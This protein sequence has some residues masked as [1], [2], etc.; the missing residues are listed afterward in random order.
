MI[1]WSFVWFL[2]KIR[3]YLTEISWPEMSKAARLESYE[4]EGIN[5]FE[6]L[7][8]FASLYSLL[9]GTALIVAL[10][11]AIL[12]SN[13]R[14]VNW[15]VINMSFDHVGLIH[16]I[17]GLHQSLDEESFQAVVD[18][19]PSIANIPL[20]LH[21]VKDL[22]LSQADADVLS[23]G[24]MIIGNLDDSVVYYRFI[25]SDQV[26]QF[27][28]VTTYGPLEN[29]TSIA[30]VAVVLFMT[31][32]VFIWVW[33][34]S[35]KLVLLDQ[36]ATRFGGGDF[37]S[38]V[39]ENA[40]F[41]VGGLN[42]S[43]NQMARRIQN[44]IKGNKNLTNAVAHELRTPVS[45]IRFQLDMM[46]DE[47]N[48]EKR[49][50]YMYGISDDIEELGDLVDELLTFA[51]FEREGRAQNFQE[52][53]LHE[54]LNNVV[55]ASNLA[56]AIEVMYDQDWLEGGSESERRMLPYEPKYLERAIG[57]LV[58]NAQK[59]AESQVRINVERSVNICTIL[60]DDDGPGIP[61]GDRE[62]IFEPF[63]RLDNSRTR[64]TGGYGLGL[65]IVKQIVEWHGGE[66]TISDSPIGGARFSLS[67]PINHK[68]ET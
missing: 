67:W 59:Y 31:L 28:P 37:H 7:R 50:Q 46:H 9:L 44:L 65:A 35:R 17:Q 52:Y 39:S 51:R 57:N 20:F 56:D 12:Y 15:R 29:A 3:Q 40:R 42:K 34:L 53:S 54:S 13:D 58:A 22:E 66:I 10:M 47:T 24:N 63:K 23:P 61:V 19:Y 33:R 41:Q 27:G 1:L 38:R 5:G 11:V 21:D 6:M 48:E 14:V 68:V 43:F 36:A 26:A 2:D 32:G 49:N 4:N 25:D 60:V 45:R 62:S 8:L 18:D 64:D 55:R 30:L 16:M